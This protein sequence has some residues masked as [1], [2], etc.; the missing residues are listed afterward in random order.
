MSVLEDLL[1]S[2]DHEW[3]KLDGNIVTV[4]ITDHAQKQLGDIVFVELPEP[5]DEV[6]KGEPF[7]SVES[8]K[9]V[10]DCFAPATGRVTEVNEL[11]ADNPETINSDPYGAGWLMKFEISDRSELDDLLSAEEYEKLLQE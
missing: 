10:S 5:D 3:A 1:Y 8:T 9:A 2:K 4:G 7:G 6:T 11:L